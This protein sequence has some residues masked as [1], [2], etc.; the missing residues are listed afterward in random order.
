MAYQKEW[1]LLSE[2]VERV[3]AV[4]RCTEDEARR[5]IALALA[6]HKITL[7]GRIREVMDGEG[8]VRSN[9]SDHFPDAERTQVS[10]V[11]FSPP[12]HLAASDFDWAESRPRKYW[13]A[14]R[15]NSA[16]GPADQWLLERI[17]LARG[18]VDRALCDGKER[19][20]TDLDSVLRAAAM[21]A[22]GSVTQKNAEEIARKAGVF[23]TRN[24]IR[25]RL[26]ALHIEGIQGRKKNAVP[27][28]NSA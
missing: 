11:D 8:C 18:E 6:D 9:W 14:R 5:D 1:L 20:A 25:D 13:P 4:N 24:E 7:R 12:L 10:G 23:S 3:T 19:P 28:R 16:D 21:L 27:P 22:G 26:K 17:E 2:A 15:R